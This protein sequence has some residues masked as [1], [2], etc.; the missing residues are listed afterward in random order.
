MLVFRF[1]FSIGNRFD[2]VCGLYTYGNEV[3]LMKQV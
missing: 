2:S 1:W 3:S